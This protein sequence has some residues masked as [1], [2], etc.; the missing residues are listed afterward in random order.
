MLAPALRDAGLMREQRAEILIGDAGRHER[1]QQRG[2]GRPAPIVVRR[3]LR[4]F[5]SR[6]LTPHRNSTMNAATRGIRQALVMARLTL[7]TG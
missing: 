6:P 2:T 5:D 4:A 7:R 3:R 1:H